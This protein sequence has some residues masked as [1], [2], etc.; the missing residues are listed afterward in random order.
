MS[1]NSWVF[2]YICQMLLGDNLS[3]SSLFSPLADYMRLS[4]A[5]QSQFV[6]VV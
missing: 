3:V 5:R 2:A 1:P 4:P 6:G